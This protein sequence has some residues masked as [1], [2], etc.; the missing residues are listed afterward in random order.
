MIEKWIVGKHE[1]TVIS[2]TRQQNTNFPS[3]VNHR[4]SHH[5]EIPYYGGY[6]VCESI[7]NPSIAK[8]IASAPE[9]RSMLQ[10]FINAIEGCV[11]NE[12]GSFTQTF[13]PAMIN[14]AKRIIK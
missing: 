1:S 11:P 2:D 7:A 8:F 6:L 10:Q 4:E 9:M 14:E 13:G 5:A 12:D 3:P